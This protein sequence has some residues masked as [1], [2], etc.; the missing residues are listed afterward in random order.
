MTPEST[1]GIRDNAVFRFL[2]S[3]FYHESRKA[4]VIG[5]GNYQQNPNFPSVTTSARTMND[6]L[7]QHRANFPNFATTFW[8]NTPGEP[9][10][11]VDE[12]DMR[13][14][15]AD[16]FQS[17]DNTEIG[18]LYFV[19][20][21]ESTGELLFPPAGDDVYDYR[22][23][24]ADLMNMVNNSRFKNV[25][26]I[27]DAC[28]AG[29]LGVDNIKYFHPWNNAGITSTLRQGVSILMGTSG[30]KPADAYDQRSQRYTFFSGTVIEALK[31]KAADRL[32]GVVTLTSI[33]D[34]ASQNMG[35]RQHPILRC[36]TDTY[37]PIR[38]H[39]VNYTKA[40]LDFIMKK[41]KI[42]K[43]VRKNA[44]APN[45]WET[46]YTCLESDVTEKQ[47][48]QME[49]LVQRGFAYLH[50]SKNPDPD[51]RPAFYYLST[52]GIRLHDLARNNSTI[53]PID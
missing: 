29:N 32:T 2:Q 39:R 9:M 38:S 6:L 33:Y 7:R 1:L 47:K 23:R 41:F 40:D 15:V 31:G 4:L 28:Y 46:A 42:G 13:Q 19:G 51:K 45:G 26:L 44:K 24:F 25:L 34:F 52:D 20:H 12:N 3:L 10:P 49:S 48:P 21:G 53:T 22:L 18:L 16:F 14:K 30:E 37:V 17:G 35:T 11:Y 50:E 43:D 27:I 5:F 36:N 8:T